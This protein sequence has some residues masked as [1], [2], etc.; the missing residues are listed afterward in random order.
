M[1]GQR[2][3]GYRRQRHDNPAQDPPRSTIADSI[4]G[5]DRLARIEHDASLMSSPPAPEDLLAMWAREYYRSGDIWH[6]YRIGLYVAEDLK[7]LGKA[8]G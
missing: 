6:L 5:A 2:M 8:D 4:L 7:L 1:K 3:A